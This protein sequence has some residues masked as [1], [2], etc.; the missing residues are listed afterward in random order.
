LDDDDD[1][2]IF[3]EVLDTEELNSPDRAPKSSVPCSSIV[4]VVLDSG[5]ATS[6]DV[7]VV[8]DV[9]RGS[10]GEVVDNDVDT[11]LS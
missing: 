6:V 1:D 11:L 5:I 7:V 9:K 3:S 8:V 4:V 2:V 10:R